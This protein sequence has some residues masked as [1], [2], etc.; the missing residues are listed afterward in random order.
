MVGLLLMQACLK[1]PIRDMRKGMM[2]GWPMVLYEMLWVSCGHTWLSETAFPLP[3]S[4]HLDVL[5]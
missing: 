1:N 5:W 4:L 2:L 3:S